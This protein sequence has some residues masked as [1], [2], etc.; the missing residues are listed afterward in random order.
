M[1]NKIVKLT[2]HDSQ[3][4]ELLVVSGQYKNASEVF[5][6]GLRLLKE[7]HAGAGQKMDV[8]RRVA[9]QGFDEIDQGKAVRL[10]SATSLQRHLNKLGRYARNE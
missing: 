10:T 6:A 9:K 8:L 1:S 2:D 4:V 3:F 7:S 5:C